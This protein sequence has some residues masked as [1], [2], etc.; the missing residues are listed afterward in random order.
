MGEERQCGG[1]AQKGRLWGWDKGREGYSSRSINSSTV[2]P[3]SLMILC[4]IP[5]LRVPLLGT[6]VRAAGLSRY[7]VI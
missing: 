6:V 1:K 7:R 2:S 3:A 4:S 5:G